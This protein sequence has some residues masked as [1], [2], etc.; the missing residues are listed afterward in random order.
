MI[1]DGLSE[2]L[3]VRGRPGSSGML[4]YMNDSTKGEGVQAYDKN[5]QILRGESFKVVPKREIPG[6]PPQM[7]AIDGELLSFRKFLKYESVPEALD[8]LVDFDILM[9]L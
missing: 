7:L 1:N 3:V 8:V 4:K 2:L 6:N 5:Y 9:E